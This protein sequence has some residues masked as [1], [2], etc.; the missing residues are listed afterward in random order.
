MVKLSDQNQCGEKRV[1]L[2]I[3]PGN[4]P[5][6]RESG[7]KLKQD[8]KPNYGGMLLAGSLTGSPSASF[9]RQ[10]TLPGDGAAH[11]GL[12]SLA[13][14]IRTITTD[15]TDMPQAGLI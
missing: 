9:L 8:L 5:S 13:S 12:S 14:V 7:Q 1:Y 3:R 15:T 10:S 11:S 2:F 4:S 6:L